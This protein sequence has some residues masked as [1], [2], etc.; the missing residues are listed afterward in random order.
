M[1]NSATATKRIDAP[2]LM[3]AESDGVKLAVLSADIVVAGRSRRQDGLCRGTTNSR[4]TLLQQS[5]QLLGNV[6]R[7]SG[8][9]LTCPVMR[10]EGTR[11]SA[12]ASRL[13][14]FGAGMDINKDWLVAVRS[15]LGGM[16]PF[17]RF[18]SRPSRPIRPIFLSLIHRSRKIDNLNP[19]SPPSSPPL[20]DITHDASVFIRSADA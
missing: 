5:Y 1:P 17:H 3:T 10:R 14:P 15:Y 7:I 13:R 6:Q 2:M 11:Q 9:P 18:S 4:K 20:F 19:P 16:G 8:A 12:A